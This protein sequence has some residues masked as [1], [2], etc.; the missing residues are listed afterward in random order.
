MISKQ[1][2]QQFLKFLTVLLVLEVCISVLLRMTVFL[3]NFLFL[4]LLV[5]PLLFVARSIG[6]LNDCE[7]E[8]RD[9]FESMI[10]VYLL[11]EME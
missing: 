6:N 7:Y 10:G 3:L 8:H 11:F 4:T 1:R 2:L 5:H 9:G